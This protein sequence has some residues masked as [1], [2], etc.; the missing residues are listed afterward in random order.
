MPAGLRLFSWRTVHQVALSVTLRR[1]HQS[2][3]ADHM[4]LGLYEELPQAQSRLEIQL[5]V[6][7]EYPK[8]SGA[9]RARPAAWARLSRYCRSCSRRRY[10]PRCP[11][12]ARSP[13]PADCRA[14]SA[15][16]RSFRATPGHVPIVADHRLA[17]GIQILPRGG[18]EKGLSGSRLR[19]HGAFQLSG[20]N[21]SSPRT[22]WG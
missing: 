19:T 2:V 14:P 16:T 1:A 13:A 10:R 12:P 6:E 9:P 5:T 17:G 11:R 3:H 8:N 18:T 4:G 7:G 21:E 15:R 20:V 22:T